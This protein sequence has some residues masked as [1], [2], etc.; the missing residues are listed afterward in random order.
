MSYGKRSIRLRQSLAE[1]LSKNWQDEDSVSNLESLLRCRVVLLV[2][3]YSDTD[4]SFIKPHQ[5]N[6]D[7]LKQFHV[8]HSPIHH[9][10]YAYNTATF[11]HF[12]P[13]SHSQGFLGFFQSHDYV[14]FFLS[15]FCTTKNQTLSQISLIY[16]NF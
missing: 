12:K 9:Q 11:S 5:G 10:C 8:S 4:T 1:N 6:R 16:V 7:N 15:I 13:L 2:A 14:V 3:Q